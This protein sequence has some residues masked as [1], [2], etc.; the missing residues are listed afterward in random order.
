M[1]WISKSPKEVSAIP[2]RTIYAA[3]DLSGSM[4]GTPLADAKRAVTEFIEKSDL[5]HT[6]IGIMCFAD[7]VRVDQDAIQDARRLKQAVDGWHIGSVGGGNSAHPFDEALTRLGSAGKSYLIVLTDGVWSGQSVAE[8][9]AKEC[10]HAGIEI[11]ALGFGGADEAFLKRIATADQAALLSGS[12][13]L[14]AALGDIAQVL[15]EDTAS[16][17]NFGIRWGKGK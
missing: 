6:S 16:G 11:I 8:A 4:S 3:V 10:H 1:S 14:V 9:R 2:H 7:S 13:D 15:V 12:G 5:A 17:A